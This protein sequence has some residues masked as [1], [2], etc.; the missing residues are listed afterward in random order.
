M[1]DIE[2]LRQLKQ[3]PVLFIENCCKIKN[4]NK[5]IVPFKLNKQQKELLKIMDEHRFTIICK[6]RQIGIS[7]VVAARAVYLCITQPGSSCLLMS[8]RDS[9][10]RDIYRKLKEIYYSIPSFLSVPLVIENKDEMKFA[11]GSSITVATCG[12]KDVAHGGTYHYVH[13]SEVALCR[14][15][16]SD[17]LASIE[18]ALTANGSMC[19][20]STPQGGITYF[21]ELYMAAER[22]DNLYHPVFFSWVEDAGG[23][24]SEEQRQ[25][26]QNYINKHGSLPSESELD[27]EELSLLNRGATYEM[28]AW[29]RIKIGNLKSQSKFNENFPSDASTAFMTATSDNLFDTERIHMRLNAIKGTEPIPMPK[30]LPESL[31]PFYGRALDLWETSKIGMEYYI[32]VDCSEGIGKDSDFSV[33]EILDRD[34]MQVGELRTKTKP[35]VF[36]ELCNDIGT[37]YNNGMLVV[38]KASAGHAVLSKLKDD[39]N[40]INLYRSKEY[41]KRGKARKTDGF[42]TNGKS[43]PIMIADMVE[44]YE[45]G[46][47][48]VNSKILLT[49]MLAFVFK[50][51]KREAQTGHDDTVMAMAMAIQAA[52]EGKYYV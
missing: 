14:D 38:E 35:F 16:I 42:S 37:Y 6:Q 45:K 15:S 5:A 26:A 21:S 20:E 13:I 27:A 47:L 19:L 44:W 25:Y 32:G 33:I 52:K 51:G 28:L 31:K 36:A 8:Y 2:K 23:M 48:C 39:Y 24:H 29:R 43:K 40:Y 10:V 50:D 30:D 11:N 4:K 22:G 17:Q 9:S 3:N 49:E 1:T 7:S 12:T 34:G 18:S 41:D 46:L